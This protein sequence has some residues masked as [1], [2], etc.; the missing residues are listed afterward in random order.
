MSFDSLLQFHAIQRAVATMVVREYDF[1]VPY[2]VV[3]LDATH[4]K[5][6]EEKPVQKFFVNAGIY[7]LSPEALQFVPSRTFFD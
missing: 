4:I 2:G 1:Q 5:T 3:R 7:A 6:I